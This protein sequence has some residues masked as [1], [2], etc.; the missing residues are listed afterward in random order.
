MYTWR[1][2]LYSM[3][4]STP[5]PEA[6]RD[7]GSPPDIRRPKR[8]ARKRLLNEFVPRQRDPLGAP[9]RL[10]GSFRDRFGPQSYGEPLGVVFSWG[11]F[12]FESYKGRMVP[13]RPFLQI[14]LEGRSAAILAGRTADGRREKAS[15]LPAA[16]SAGLLL[17][18]SPFIGRQSAPGEALRLSIAKLTRQTKGEA[19]SLR[20]NGAKKEMMSTSACSWSKP[21]RQGK[22]ALE[23]GAERVS[24]GFIKRR[25]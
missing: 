6:G 24:L 11:D 5:S 18:F 23:A 4:A 9:S 12:L 10:D 16:Q 15:P 7:L 19:N 17:A 20:Y 25:Q 22:I 2:R 1:C 8:Y 14:P 21:A 13:L 3:T